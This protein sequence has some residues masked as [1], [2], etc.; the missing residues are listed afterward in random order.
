MTWLG[1]YTPPPCSFN[2]VVVNLTVT[3]K[4]RQFDRLGSIYLGDVE[5]F[6]TSTAEPTVDGIVWNYLKD[7]SHYHALWTKGQRII[8]DLPNIV[9]GTYTGPLATT[10]TAKFFT[11]PGAPTAADLI[12]PISA[13]RAAEGQGSAFTIQGNIP[14][15]QVDFP[16]N[17]ERAVVSL[18]AC[19]QLA[20][21]FWY[22]HALSA[23]IHTFE[24][25]TGI[26][27]G[28][29][30]FREVQ[31]L[32]DGDLA[33][34]VWPFPV[35]FTGGIVPGLWRPIAG[36]DAFDLRQHEIDVTPWLPVLC[37]GKPHTFGIRVAGLNDDGTLSDTV[38]S[39]WLAAGTIF[40]FLDADGSHS[41][42]TAPAS[43]APDPRVQTSSYITTNSSGSNESLTYTTNVQRSLSIS[44]ILS[45]TSGTRPVSWTQQLSYSNNNR[46]SHQGL[47]GSTLQSTTGFDRAS[48]TQYTASYN[49]PLHLVSS[50][51]VSSDELSIDGS[52]D[53][54]LIFNV[55]GPTIA[56][57]ASRQSS[58]T[59]PNTQSGGLQ[60]VSLS[61]NQQGRAAY[62]DV[63]SG[64][65]KRPYSYGTTSQEYDFEATNIGAAVDVESYH[66]WVKSV[67]SSVVENDERFVS[68]GV[69]VLQDAQD[70][71]RPSADLAQRL[72][73]QAWE[74]SLVSV[75]KA[76]GRGPDGRF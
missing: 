12:I 23:D 41:T 4:G 55:V 47:V 65:E 44:S 59:V 30:P 1:N 49:Y 68:R 5:V 39:Y 33:G 71:G 18:S 57:H 19:G 53:R 37:D 38:E 27:D 56:P 3:S 62:F 75:R 54:G 46:L 2:R 25:T 7:M 20:E 61:T 51:S 72:S 74:P 13:R 70:F 64:S 16:P 10:V 17:V 35:I 69:K 43:V 40:V 26:L 28:Y 63:R 36:I 11:V 6:R 9:D 58:S 15:V 42:G 22:T 34:V 48:N 14:T 76:L 29:S 73:D 52:I 66:R 60:S 32:I 67:N 8:F 24:E 45:T 50:F 31:L 21:E